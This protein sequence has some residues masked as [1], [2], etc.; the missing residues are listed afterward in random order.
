MFD[1]ILRSP[2]FRN[3]AS[4]AMAKLISKKLDK[5]VDISIHNLKVTEVNEYVEVYLTVTARMSENDLKA[6][7]DGF[8]K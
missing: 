5:D 6:I 2:M 8:V 7:L 1:I 3:V 4:K